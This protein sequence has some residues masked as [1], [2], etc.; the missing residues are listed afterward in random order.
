MRK[1][2][3][4]GWEGLQC[5]IGLIH[6]YYEQHDHTLGH[7]QSTECQ[8]HY[9]HSATD[10]NLAGVTALTQGGGSQHSPL[11]NH[12][13]E[14]SPKHISGLLRGHIRAVAAFRAA[15]AVRIV[16]TLSIRRAQRAVLVG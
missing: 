11:R 12:G 5:S 15:Q 14:I 6:Q 7:T 2:V 3:L 1:G 16:Q 9:D 13:S 4:W 10:L 8:T